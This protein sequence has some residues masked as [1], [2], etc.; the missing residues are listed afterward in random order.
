MCE[1]ATVRKSEVR[2]MLLGASAQ[3]SQMEQNSNSAVETYVES[4][5]VN[6]NLKCHTN[7]SLAYKGVSFQCDFIF[8][9]A[10]VGRG[11]I[12]RVRGSQDL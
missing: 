6:R 5:G 8:R 12:L 3:G 11:T 2:R 1:S 4:T 10:T 7:Q 9:D